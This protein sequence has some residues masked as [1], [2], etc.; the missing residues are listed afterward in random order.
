MLGQTLYADYIKDREG[1]EVIDAEHGFV[2]FKVENNEC[3][4]LNIYVAPQA[5]K[6]GV[7]GMLV[8]A[9]CVR[10]EQSECN[11]VLAQV[12]FNDKNASDTLMAALKLGFKV[13]AGNNSFIW[14]VK[15]LGGN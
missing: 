12:H 3:L 15:S 2:T 8:D 9:V 1:A 7:A 14:I 4:L 10:A 6:T 5:R 11:A 13:L